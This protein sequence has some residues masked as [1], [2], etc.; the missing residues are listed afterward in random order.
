MVRFCTIAIPLPPPMMSPQKSPPDPGW[1]KL[2]ES[3]KGLRRKVWTQTKIIS[4]NILY[5]V[6]ILGF[7]AIYFLED[8]AW[9]WS[10][11][12]LEGCLEDRLGGGLEGM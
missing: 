1:Q 10:V 6:T 12:G 7:V 8:W 4:P 3:A 11:S 2:R 5:F 9:G